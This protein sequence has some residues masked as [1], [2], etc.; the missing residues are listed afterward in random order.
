[1][2]L[3]AFALVN[4][5]VPTAAD[6]KRDVRGVELGMD[7][8]QAQASLEQKGAICR[9]WV[10][11]RECLFA[12]K[13]KIELS[14]NIKNKQVV[15]RIHFTFE[16]VQTPDAGRKLV[17]DTIREY[18]L[19]PG[20]SSGDWQMPDGS[21]LILSPLGDALSILSREWLVEAERGGKTS[22]GGQAR[23]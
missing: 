23:P 22:A 18:S 17:A 9:R 12:D 7:L 1:M 13:S 15:T 5:L 3:A 2:T 4:S 20:L 16:A 8:N 21:S 14:H 10:T 11:S 19:T 6:T